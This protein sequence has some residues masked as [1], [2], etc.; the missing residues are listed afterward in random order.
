LNV[1]AILHQRASVVDSASVD[2]AVTH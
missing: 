1:P 2:G